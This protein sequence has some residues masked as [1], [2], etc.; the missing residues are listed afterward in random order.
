MNKKLI[1][2][3]GVLF[4]SFSAIF[5]K[6]SDSSSAVLVFY[7][8]IMAVLI[9]VPLTLIKNG[10]E[11]RSVRGKPLVLSIT[12]GVF[13]GLH[14]VTFFESLKYTT[15]ASSAT[16]TSVEAFFV[17]FALVFIFREKVGAKS[18]LGIV[19]TFVGT[20]LIAAADFG[21]GSDMIKGDAL[22]L[23]ACLLMSV[24]TLIGRYVRKSGIS[25]NTY[26][27]IVYTSAAV[28]VGLF[29]FVSGTP[30]LPVSGTTLLCA[31]GLTIF[32]TFLGHSI[33]SWGLKFV[34]AS[35]I[36]NAKMLN[37]AFSMLW[38]LL[39]FGERP[40][41]VSVIGMITVISG[42]LIYSN[43]LKE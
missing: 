31:L 2:I 9:S 6:F 28:T 34:Q 13:F 32:C 3:L 17:A 42:V 24:Y 43:N 39:L 7:R 21:G 37:P 10:E 30:L 11:L 15:I 8:M 26:T 25:T 35:Y 27:C 18:W 38:G 16:L 33:Y 5:G 12:S 41:L 36:S 14:L 40:T 22:A 20:C 4:S 29:S 19:V 23:L 1:V